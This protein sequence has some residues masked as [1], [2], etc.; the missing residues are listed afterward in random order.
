MLLVA[1]A[2]LAT[3]CRGGGEA[4]GESAVNAPGV[5]DEACP[6]AVNADNGCIYL[7]TISDLTQGPFAP[8][9]VPITEAQA[10]FWNRVNEDGG[11]GGYDIDV[12]TYVKDNLYNPQTHQQ[13]YGEIEGDVLALAQTLGSPTTLAIIPDMDRDEMIG[14]PASW[15]SLWAFEDAI[16]E[17]GANYCVEGMNAVDYMVAEKDIS[18]VMAVGFPGDYG[19][20]GAAGAEI[21][22]E[23]NGLEFTGV[24]TAPGQEAQAG[25]ISAIVKQKPD[26]VLLGTGPTE[27]AV[28][29]GQAA[30]QGFQGQFIGL[31]PTWNP[32]LLETPSAPALEALYMQSGYWG[33]F[34]TETPG[35]Q[36][37]RDALGEVAQPND[38]YTAGWA[39][40][41]PLKAALEE[42]L[43]GDYDKD[44]AGLLE[45][46][47]SLETID[48]E[49]MLPE[50]AG[51][52]TG[53]PDETIFR[54]SVLSK[55]D[56][57][58][59][60]GVTIVSDFTAG[61]TASEHTFEGACFEG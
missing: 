61:P 36:A 45:A 46:V 10:A 42:W 7:G 25:A 28:I 24:E 13:V 6:E 56:P 52:R 19:G 1:L 9:G 34:G 37:M 60:S 3:G 4:E 33:P 27:T 2:L 12:T 57:S 26:L 58:A 21:A 59:P 22:A 16:L 5:T 49:G 55:V 20:D 23:A 39:W 38:G 8:L 50:E 31:G 43:D 41:Y 35:H 14:A 18:S 40:S 11:I 54:E 48:Y 15:T 30:A 44:R 17:S 32:A 51:N 29:V 53:D 47:Q